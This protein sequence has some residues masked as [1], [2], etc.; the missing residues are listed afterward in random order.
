MIKFKKITLPINSNGETLDD[1]LNGKKDT[2][3]EDFYLN[4]NT[5]I[6]LKQDNLDKDC[7]KVGIN[8]SDL[9]GYSFPRSF[10]VCKHED[11]DAYNKLL[12]Q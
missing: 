1:K 10:M 11:K 3:Y 5:I 4:K 8:F 9:K 6:F 7:I 2:V 12:G